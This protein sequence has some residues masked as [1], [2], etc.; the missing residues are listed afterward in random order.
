MGDRRH[1]DAR[2]A[3]GVA[4]VS[5][6]PLRRRDRGREIVRP[7]TRT[8]PRPP[9][10][11]QG[12]TRAARHRTTRCGPSSR[13]SSPRLPCASS[14]TSE[15]NVRLRTGGRRRE[16]GVRGRSCRGCSRRRR[17]A[18]GSGSSRV[19][20]R[21]AAGC[22]TTPR[23]T[24]RRRGARC[25]SA[26]IGRRRR[27][28]AAVAR[29]RSDIDCVR[30]RACMEAA[31]QARQW[32]RGRRPRARSGDSRARRR[33]RRRDHR[34]GS[35]DGACD[36]ADPDLGTLRARRLVRHPRR[37]ERTPRRAR[38]R[39]RRR[40][41]RD[42]ARRADAARPVPRE[43]GSRGVRRDHRDRGRARGT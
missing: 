1:R 3:G 35:L 14:S 38:P 5:R 6:S 2:C 42:R 23:G 24:P 31:A 27:R 30:C 21:T 39:C 40:V 17:R 32:R 41:R 28:I 36:R 20:G 10:S 34:D 29:R 33:S 12:A 8:A 9:R 25:R 7:R 16:R 26:A 11:S 19:P 13:R 43:H 4:A 18:S 37:S 15:A 22:S